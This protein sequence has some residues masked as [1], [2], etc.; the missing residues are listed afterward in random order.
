M[1]LPNEINVVDV[2]TTCWEPPES[3][4]EG[5]VQDIIE[6]GIITLD[7]LCS[8]ISEKRSILVRPERS[9]VSDFCTRL[10]T[11]TQ[12][13]LYNQGIPFRDALEIL[14]SEYK[15]S[16]RIWC[17]WGDFDRKIF[18]RQC[19]EMGF[20]YPFGPRHINIK[21]LYKV[22][23]CLPKEPGMEEALALEQIPLTGTHHRGHD[24]AE[25]IA[26]IALRILRGQLLQN[27][28]G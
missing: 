19:E 3:R 26:K 16:K 6:I 4:P 24:D 7:V 15:S 8:K 5:E 23:N 9:T 13:M 2:E 18:E 12:E 17:S 20:A 27:R 22:M 10:T 28:Q 25:N 14:R 1:K 11:I 21:C